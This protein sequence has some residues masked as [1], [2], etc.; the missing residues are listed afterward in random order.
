MALVASIRS[1]RSGE[2]P[3]VSSENF[4]VMVTVPLLSWVRMLTVIQP[5]EPEPDC[6]PLSQA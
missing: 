5:R 4:L 2:N 1:R 6:P 3:F